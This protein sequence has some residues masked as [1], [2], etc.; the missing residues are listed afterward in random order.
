MKN[1]DRDMGYVSNRVI[2]LLCLVVVMTFLHHTKAIC[3]NDTISL[4]DGKGRLKLTFGRPGDGA[5]I[6]SLTDTAEKRTMTVGNLPVW[7]INIE[8][9]SGKSY[10]LSS[11][12]CGR[13][14][15]E[16]TGQNGIII[17]WTLDSTLKRLVS[18]TDK[19]PTRSI[20][21]VC[22]VDVNN[23]RASMKLRVYNSSTTW[24]IRSV[25]F[26]D[27]KLAK[28]GKS[29]NDDTFVF[30]FAAGKTVGRPLAT[31]FSFGGEQNNPSKDRTGRYANPWTTMQFCALWDGASGLYVGAEDPYASVKY[32]EAKS[33]GESKT[34]S[35]RFTWPAEDAGIPGNNF[36]HPGSV[37]LEIFDGDWY[38]AARIYRR[39]AISEAGWWPA[40]G[41]EGRV[42]TP[43]WMKETA[44]W[45]LASLSD[46]AVSKTIEFADFMG[47]PT[48]MH[49]YNWH[50]VPFD[51]DYPHYFPVKDG[52]RDGV[53]KLKEAGVR[54]M[55]YINARLWDDDTAD[56]HAVALPA[57]TKKENGDYYFE[58]YGSKQKL[59]PM[60]PTTFLWQNTIS[61]IVM[62]LVGPKIDVDGVYLDQVSAMSP[63]LCFDPTHGHP[64]G[65]GHW[66]TKDGYWPMVGHIKDVLAVDYPDKILTSECN[67]EPYIHGFDGYLMWHCQF[68]NMVPLFSAVYG[69]AIQQFGRA[70]S[71]NDQVAHRMRIA[72]S[73]VFGEQLGWINP[74]ILSEKETAGF[75]RDAA[76]A[77][78][79]LVP[80]LSWGDM[81]RPPVLTGDIPAI[82]GDWAWAAEEKQVTDSAV[83]RGAWKAPDGRVAFIFANASEETVEFTWRFDQKHYGFESKH[84]TVERVHSDDGMKTIKGKANIPVK[85]DDL[86]ITAFII[87]PQ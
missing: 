12:E 76:C 74:G 51:N 47:V 69:G 36:E 19:E 54:V 22:A 10:I 4:Q 63:V 48:A 15:I 24:S 30:P 31:K 28:L 78:F 59:V 62:N 17:R 57:A 66:W 73:L 82:T 26:P 68:N 32:I 9:T 21:A 55:P 64:L 80:F 37:A 79:E 77:R 38:D 71:G 29:D 45:V 52:F 40:V 6:M 13:P 85:L 27:L 43:R 87:T 41:N 53:K 39:W 65:G 81:M 70:F 23:G 50:Q 75:L 18:E 60:C 56:F 61:T 11:L 7:S 16:R 2:T 84:L 20:Q 58:T 8:H 49:L 14:K 72:Q 42:D 3:S 33:D 67:A 44:V 1:S 83:Q 25:V 86:D 34:M 46:D 5:S 35:V